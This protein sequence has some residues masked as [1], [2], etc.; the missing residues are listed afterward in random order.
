[1]AYE[2]TARRW[3]PQNFASVIGQD[4]VTTTLKNAIQSQQIA[5]AYLFSGPRGVG[6][7]TTARI[8]AKALN[9]VNGPTVTPCNECSLCLEIA[10]ARSVDVLEIDGASNNKV[11]QVRSNLVET[12]NY[13]PSQGKHKIYIIDE[14]HMLSAA[15][16]NALLKTLEEPPAHVYFIFATTEP[17]KVLPTVLS[18]CQHFDFRPMSGQIIID[19]LAMIAE[20]SGYEIE[21]EALA[22]IARRAGGSMRDAESLFDQVIA[23]GGDTLTARDVAGVLGLVEQD[24][25]FELIDQVASHNVSQGLQLLDR[26]LRHAVAMRLFLARRV[27]SFLCGCRRAC[28]AEMVL[29]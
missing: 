29:H 21:Q 1:M 8:L 23:F 16:F 7:T 27:V 5:H 4:H 11:E 24:I 15:S 12:V 25:Y 17:R 28:V 20:R 19:H 13:T 3:R 2:V 26:I 6:K 14:V 18:R 22:L 9:C 10:E